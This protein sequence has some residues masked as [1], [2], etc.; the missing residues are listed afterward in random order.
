MRAWEFLTENERAPPI[1]LRHVN[2]AKKDVLSRD[3]ANDDRMNVVSVMY[4]DLDRDKEWIEVEKMRLDLEQ[5]RLELKR[6]KAELG[7]PV[8]S[9]NNDNSD[10]V[11]KLAKAETDRRRKSR[12]QLSDIAVT[13][14]RNQ[15]K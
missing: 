4:R 12:Q 6:L 8:S 11:K 15:Q 2:N 13:V 14:L 1:T 10:R 3:R 9:P 5:Q 7:E